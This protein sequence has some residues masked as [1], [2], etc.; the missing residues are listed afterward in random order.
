MLISNEQLPPLS[1]SIKEEDTSL[2]TES[3]FLLESTET[4]MKWLDSLLQTDSSTVNVHL[5]QVTDIKAMNEQDLA[6]IQLIK[7]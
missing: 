6:I 5:K 1:P 7:V 4:Q 3:E 2:K